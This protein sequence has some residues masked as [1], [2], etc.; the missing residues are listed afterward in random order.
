MLTAF[1]SGVILGCIRSL[2]GAQH[3]PK[4]ENYSAFY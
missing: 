2:H 3:Y 1:Q 4:S